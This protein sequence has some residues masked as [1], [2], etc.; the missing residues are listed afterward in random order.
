M[1]PWDAAELEFDAATFCGVARLFPLP[2]VV[3]YPHVMQPLHIFEERYREMLEDALAGDKL[4]AM[5]MLEPGWEADYDSRPPVSPYACLGKVVAH[6][7]LE[8]GTYNV[9]LLGVERV[10]IIEELDPLRSF[11]QAK[12]DIVE[13]RYDFESLAERKRT[14]EKLITAFRRQLPCTCQLP[15]QLEEMLS[16]HLPLGLLTDLAAYALPLD[17]DVKRKLL[18]EASVNA[19]AHVLLE[20][21]EQMARIARS[22]SSCFPPPFSE[23]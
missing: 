22:K 2:N 11:R 1:K 15:E 8:D 4:I 12:V 18:A 21:V 23:N 10:R 13:D 14:Q 17:I 19:R 9:L 5:A 20:Q 3:L 7:R 6:H 16:R